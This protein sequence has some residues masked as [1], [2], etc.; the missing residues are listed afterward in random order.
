MEIKKEVP[1]MLDESLL[2]EN[3]QAEIE[4]AQRKKELMQRLKQYENSINKGLDPVTGR[5]FPHKSIEGGRDTL[6]Y[7]DKLLEGKYSPEEMK[8]IYDY[9]M[10]QEEVDAALER[11]IDKAQSDAQAIMQMKGIKNL[12]P[13][14]QEALTEMVF[15]IGRK[16]TLGFNKLLE[17]LKRND[18]RSAEQEALDSLW[19]Q[20]TPKRAKE[21]AQRLR[22]GKL[23]GRLA[24]K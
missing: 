7:G 22:F 13:I 4:E 17:A 14:Q 23:A 15:Q 3:R 24:K 16:G 1:L 6:A 8:R 19:A 21:V 20:Q 9:G 18:Y 5:Y 11:N 2:P 10:S 12:D